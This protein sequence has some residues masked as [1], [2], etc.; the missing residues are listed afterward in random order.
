MKRERTT[1]KD[2]AEEL[3]L[4]TATVSNVIHGKAG[5]VSE[6]TIHRVNKLLEERKYIPNM[7][8]L[9]LAR[10]SSR[11]VGV[12]IYDHPKYE[13]RILEDGFIASSLNAL[14]RELERFGYFMMVKTASQWEE[15]EKFGSMWNMEGL[16]LMGFCQQEY[17]KLREN[18]RIPFVV[19]DG[20]FSETERI[21]NVRIDDYDGGFQVGTY[22]KNMGHRHILCLSDNE[23]CM[24]AERMRGVRDGVP[25]GS[26]DHLLL[27]MEKKLR[28]DFYLKHFQ[29][30]MEYTAVFAVSDS[31]GA[32]FAHF[33]QRHGVSVPD[34]I[35]IVGF[36]DTY[37]SRNCIPELTTVRQNPCVRARTA[38]DALKELRNGS[39]SQYTIT[40]PVE[41]IVRKS[42][43]KISQP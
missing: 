39:A 18:M 31:Y 3:G 37:S 8:G 19:Y 16:V 6:E 26:V 24:D 27:P 33:M 36:D 35:S 7:A 4:S 22:L 41:L 30:I 10:N 43:R 32:E 42:V 12:V 34:D 29:K 15:I 20:F 23:I 28:E 2:I 38:L 11:I 21:V 17:K 14:L 1:I 25:E 13:G 9:L 5:R 40:L